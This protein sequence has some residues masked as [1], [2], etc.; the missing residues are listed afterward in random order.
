MA[1]RNKQMKK[2][3]NI[4]PEVV[5][6]VFLVLS[7]LAVYL[8]VQY[9]AFIN[10]DDNMYIVENPY[11]QDGLT[12]KNIKWAFTA[13]Y[14]A[15]WH[16]L[17]WLSHML[18]VQLYGMN[19]GMH[20]LTSLLFHIANT[21]L[22]LVVLNRMTGDLWPSG[23]VAALFAL[24]PLHVESVAWAAE[25]KDVLSTF[26]WMLTMTSYVGYVH[27][28]DLKRYL[29]VLLFF[30]L[31]LMAKPMLVTLPFVLLLIDYWPL[32]RFSDI[33]SVFRLVREKI[34]FLIFTTLSCVVTIVAQRSAGAVKSL[35]IYPFGIRVSNALVSYV[36]Y[37]I[38]MVYPHRLTAFYPHP[39][40]TL[41]MWQ[42]LGSG[43]V[44]ILVSIIALRLAREH[45]YFCVGWLWYLGTLLPVIGL[46]QV[47]SQAMADRY[48][49][50]PLIGLFIMVAWGAPL[51]FKE[52]RH[53][54]VVLVTGVGVMLA[55]LMIVTWHQVRQW[56][57]NMTLFKNMI[58]VTKGNYLGHNGFGLSLANKGLLDQAI[59]QYNEAIR[60]KPDFDRAY[61]NLGLALLMQG[62]VQEAVDHLKQAVRINKDDA[63]IHNNLG[64]ALL[65]SG[66][67]D[68]AI[69]HFQ[70]AILI[71]P[72]YVG[73]QRNLMNAREVFDSLGPPERAK[74]H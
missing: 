56:R 7:T 27:R 23:F 32:E 46:T 18:D 30:I 42:I 12:L 39:G 37:I 68:Q 48:T 28:P 66:K 47:G 25:R 16:P 55:A 34:P 64:V 65:A 54:S 11:V 35:E 73:A 44:V 19:P 67:T 38:K 29:S 8:Q 33:S 62:A 4:S 57:D 60:I 26:F 17:T 9:H 14:A 45:P 61:N 36:S 50:V 40:A 15:N 63:K 51:I 3:V 1:G 20:H 21:L 53:G 6:A 43:L 71:Q 22:L 41:P 74:A 24:H 10:Y 70:T 58:C 69:S 2:Q 31:G 59:V 52:R 49:Y 5:V 13:T 72:N